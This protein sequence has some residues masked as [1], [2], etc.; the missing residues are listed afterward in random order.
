[1]AESSHRPND[2][3]VTQRCQLGVITDSTITTIDA[4]RD[5]TVGVSLTVLANARQL[6]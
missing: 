3:M 1:M 4:E 2:R 5:R 6:D